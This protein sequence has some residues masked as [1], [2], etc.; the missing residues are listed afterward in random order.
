MLK[1]SSISTSY[2]GIR[3]VRNVSVEIP[4][5][6]MVALIGPNGA[7]KST[8]LKTICGLVA[9][10]SGQIEFDGQSITKKEAYRIARAGL[11]LV[12][13]GRQILGPLTVEENLELGR[14][15]AGE[16]GSGRHEIERVYS[17]FP[18][19][20]ERRKQEGGSLSGGQQQMLA[21]G[22]AL[23]GCP[24]VL[25]L[26]EPSLG[27]SPLMAKQVFTALER[28][29]ADGL[30]IFLVEQNAKRALASTRYAY[31]L[32]RGCIAHQGA[33]NEMLNDPKVIAHYLGRDTD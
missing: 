17:I 1:I 29:N 4:G 12:P 5:G 7:G 8:L 18:V 6:G 32:E 25:L 28:L 22:R 24:K 3:A 2:S 20:A 9:A 26:D 23:M 27:L 21:I 33:S 10:D 11:L 30:T 13:E 15:A 14:L 19:L 16:R 31:V